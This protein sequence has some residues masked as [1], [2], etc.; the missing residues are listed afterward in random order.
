MNFSDEYISYS[1]KSLTSGVIRDFLLKNNEEH[2]E[3]LT[4]LVDLKMYA[5][6]LSEKSVNFNIFY[7][8]ELVGFA[9]CYFN[10]LNKNEAYLS[11]I[12]ILRDFQGFR[13]GSNL[14]LQIINYGRLKNFNRIVIRPKCKNHGLIKFLEKNEFELV[15]QSDIY[16]VFE[17][18]LRI[19]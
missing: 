9:G 18:D 13:L 11:C 2:F 1:N 12:S 5:K 8:S 16:C 4:D 10:D 17:Y 15:H 19:N 7:E 3:K 14:I 6:K